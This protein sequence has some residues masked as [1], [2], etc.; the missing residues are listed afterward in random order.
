MPASTCAGQLELLTRAAATFDN[1]LPSAG[2]TLDTPH[3]EVDLVAVRRALS[4][5]R[6]A[7]TFAEQLYLTAR[8]T[9][10]PTLDCAP[11]ALNPTTTVV[12]LRGHRDDPAFAD[13]VYVGRALRMGGWNLLTSP[14]ADPY[15]VG[16][17]GSLAKVLAR[18]EALLMSRADLR[19]LARSLRGRRL[20]CWC[21]PNPCHAELIAR[22]ADNEPERH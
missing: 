14:L 19:A 1:R 4:G 10:R 6:T 12:N 3:G 9:V 17:D 5:A 20:G 11:A 18:Y 7:L 21:A 2:L 15:R 8:I 22:I 13:V 16:R